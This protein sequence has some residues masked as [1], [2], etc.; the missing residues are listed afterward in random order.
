MLL[1]KIKSTKQSGLLLALLKSE[2]TITSELA[3]AESV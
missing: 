3:E 1:V 2:E